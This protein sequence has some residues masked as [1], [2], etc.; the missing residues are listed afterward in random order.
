MHT[1]VQTHQR[2]AYTRKLMQSLCVTHA[3]TH[4]RTHAQAQALTNTHIRTL[5]LTHMHTHAHIHAQAA[6]EN[7]ALECCRVLQQ[8]GLLVYPREQDPDHDPDKGQDQDQDPDQDRGRGH[9][10]TYY[11]R[12]VLND[13]PRFRFCFRSSFFL[14]LSL[15]D[16]P[17]MS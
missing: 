6:E 17:S 1:R 7:A 10:R 4:T 2:R 3:H 11:L 9:T 8:R 13:A 15:T 14:F 5:E 12:L 16:R